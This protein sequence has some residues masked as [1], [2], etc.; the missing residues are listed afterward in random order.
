MA[1][2]M[3]AE[4]ARCAYKSS[5]PS[6]EHKTISTAH[7][8]DNINFFRTHFGVLNNHNH[9]QLII[10]TTVDGQDIQSLSQ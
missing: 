4:A 3:R 6:L 5:E 1:A 2:F 9:N 8:P 7:S 10:L